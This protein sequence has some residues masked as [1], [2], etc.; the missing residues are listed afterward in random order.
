MQQHLPVVPAAAGLRADAL[1]SPCPTATAQTCVGCAKNCYDFKPRAAYQA[2]MADPDRGWSGARKLF[3]AALPGF[4]LGFFTLR[5]TRDM[6]MPERYPLLA[7]VH[8]RQRRVV[9]RDRCRVAA[10]PVDGGGD[11]RGR[12]AEHLLLVRRPGPR[13]IARG[14]DRRQPAVAALA[15][16]ARSIAAA[17]LLW[18]ARTRV[19]RA[20]VRVDHRGA[21]RAGPAHAAQACR[22]LRSRRARPRSA[23]RRDGAAVA[24]EVG[25]SLLE[26]AERNNQ[27][28]EAGCRMGCAAPTR[29]RCS[30]ACRV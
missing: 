29:W 10:E 5:A 26:V 28:I 19:S 9:L 22:P 7:A 15:R 3:V 2:D 30:T 21:D 4:I 24:A 17:T 20:A 6:P 18:I 1:S 8:V 12:G 23:S 14:A 13:R 16:S 27:P 25:T 11:L